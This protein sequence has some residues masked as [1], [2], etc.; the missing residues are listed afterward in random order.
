MAGVFAGL[1]EHDR[2]FVRHLGDDEWHEFFVAG[3]VSQEAIVVL[4]G[5]EDHYVLE[6]RG[7]EE[8]FANRAGIVAR[9]ASMAA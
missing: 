5:D 3:L 8:L 7:V 2:A 6:A 9:G 1:R 4:T